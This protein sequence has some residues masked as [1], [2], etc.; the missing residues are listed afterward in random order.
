MQVKWGVCR[1]NTW[2]GFRTLILEDDLDKSYGVYII[3][4][5]AS[6]RGIIYVGEGNIRERIRSHRNDLRFSNIWAGS[7]VTWARV[8]RNV[9]KGV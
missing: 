1:S 9:I 6:S 7:Y 3:W 8:N 4:M 2:C 5:E